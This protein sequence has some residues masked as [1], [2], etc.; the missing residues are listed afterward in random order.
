[1]CVLIHSDTLTKNVFKIIIHYMNASDGRERENR[2][3]RSQTPTFNWPKQEFCTLYIFYY[4]RRRIS[5]RIIYL[6]KRSPF[7]LVMYILPSLP[8]ES[9]H[10]HHRTP[11][12]S[13]FFVL[14]GCVHSPFT[15]L[16]S[17]SLLLFTQP[18]FIPPH[19]TPPNAASAA[20]LCVWQEKKRKEEHTKKSCIE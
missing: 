8:I 5:I 10:H 20:T 7:C 19:A 14:Y 2:V 12:H 15:P 17:R 18:P 13:L 11:R 16:F 9:S 6:S 1:M 3:L 4:K